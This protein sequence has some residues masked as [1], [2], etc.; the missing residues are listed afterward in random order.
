MS[1]PAE[2]DSSSKKPISCWSRCS[3]HAARSRF[4][5][6]ALKMP[7]QSDSTVLESTVA[8][9][10]IARTADQNHDENHTSSCAA[11]TDSDGQ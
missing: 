10:A 2:L 5:R 1:S 7:K 6:C 8:T 3:R 4:V 11:V 9:H